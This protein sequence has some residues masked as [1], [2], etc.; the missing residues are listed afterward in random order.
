[1]DAK[2]FQLYCCGDRVRNY[3]HYPIHLYTWQHVC[4][5]VDLRSHVLTF[6]LNGDVREL[7][8]WE[9]NWVDANENQS[10]LMWYFP[11]IFLHWVG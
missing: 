4:M 11:F 7:L 2:L 5:A 10:R 9:D 8:R 1:M 6:V 3:I